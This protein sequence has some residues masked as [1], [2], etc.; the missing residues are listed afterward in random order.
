MVEEAILVSEYLKH[1]PDAVQNI[2]TA[3]EDA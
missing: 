3:R 1:H 2:N